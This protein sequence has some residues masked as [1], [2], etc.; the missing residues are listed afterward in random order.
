MKVAAVQVV[1]YGMVENINDCVGTDVLEGV[2]VSEIEIRVPGSVVIVRLGLVREPT[3]DEVL[4]G[5]P[6]S[7]GELVWE[8]V[9]VAVAAESTVESLVPGREIGGGG[10]G[11]MREPGRSTCLRSTAESAPAIVVQSAGGGGG[12]GGELNSP[13]HRVT[14]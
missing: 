10:G 2:D 12:Q 7:D 14:C 3:V 6:G 5:D 13:G 4:I 8:C 11:K 9:S 1:G